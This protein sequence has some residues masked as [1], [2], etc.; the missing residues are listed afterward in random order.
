M[1][2]YIVQCTRKST[3]IKR[4]SRIDL[5]CDRSVG[6]VV[7]IDSSLDKRVNLIHVHLARCVRRPHVGD[8]SVV[9][10]G[11]LPLG[12]LSV[13]DVVE[14]GVGAC[15]STVA[16]PLNDMTAESNGLR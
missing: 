15:K 11:V 14:S 2:P 1:I 4:G 6:P 7:P 9:T 12:F 13:D 3:A 5:S 8:D 16:C 10:F